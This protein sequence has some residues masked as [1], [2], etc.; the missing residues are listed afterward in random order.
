MKPSLPH[1][2]T[3]CLAVS[4]Q[5]YSR[6]SGKASKTCAGLQSKFGDSIVQTAG[7]E[8]LSTVSNA[9]SLFNTLQ[10]PTCVMYPR[11]A[12][13]VQVA[14]REIYRDK[15]RYAVQAGSHSGMTGW[16]N[17]DGGVL[18]AFS[19]MKD[20]KYNST[21]DIITLQPGIRWGE[22]IAAVESY[23]VAPMGGRLTDVGTGL[24]L[25]GGLSYLAPEYG[26]SAD[27]FKELDVVL[28]D[29]DLVTATATNRYSDLFRALKGGANRFGIVTRYAVEAVH[30]GT[31]EDKLWFGGLILYPEEAAE[32]LVNATA[33]FVRSVT[34]PKAALFTCLFYAKTGGVLTDT[35]LVTLFYRGPSLPLD[36]YGDFLSIPFTSQS[37]GPAS[38]SDA[39]NALGPGA[40]RGFG[41]NFG[42]S[43][44]AGPTSRYLDAL[45]HFK[46]YSSIFQDELDHTLMAFTPI[47]QSQINAGRTRGRNAIDPPDGPYAAV[48]FQDQYKQGVARI[49]QELQDGRKLLFK[50]I[51]P[52]PGLP[53]YVGESDA[54]QNA[55]ATYSGYEFLKRTYAKYDPTRFNVQYADGPPGL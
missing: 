31:K 49:S 18:F 32:A 23:G 36:I 50:Q 13:H 19:H 42:G 16:N 34:E 24:L 44:I 3:F 10:R 46:N 45:N 6:H 40:D 17:V 9:W 30:T 26:F 15:V 41:Q 43:A 47:L 25:G 29:G 33:K 21:S 28:V 1:V 8:Y 53:L 51:P 5:A 4:T 54:T 38:Y 20:V 35:H 27:L 52:S 48:V 14:M 11:N 37:L 39:V 55:F 22:A 7:A 12:N 2:L